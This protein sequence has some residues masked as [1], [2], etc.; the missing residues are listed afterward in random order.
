MTWSDLGTARVHVREGH[1]ACAAQLF[2]AAEASLEQIGSPLP[3]VD[4]RWYE[5]EVASLRS[6][7]GEQTLTRHW[8]RGRNLTMAQAAN[9]AASS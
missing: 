7:L 5:V 1:A 6:A 2:G 9:L 3:P 8:Q 4:R